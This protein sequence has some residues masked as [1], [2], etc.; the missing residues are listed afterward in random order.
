MCVP[1]LALLPLA[2]AICDLPQ[3]SR[4]LNATINQ[5]QVANLWASTMAGRGKK[6]RSYVD[7]HCTD[8]PVSDRCCPCTLKPFCTNHHCIDPIRRNTAACSSLASDHVAAR[9]LFPFSDRLSCGTES[10]SD[11]SEVRRW[12]TGHALWQ[13]AFEPYHQES[14]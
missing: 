7:K 1:K 9:G 10:N 5:C 13:E 8:S 12:M 3:T 2:H 11:E 6:S 4:S 14:R